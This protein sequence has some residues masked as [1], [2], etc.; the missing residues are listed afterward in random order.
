MHNSQTHT[1]TTL[2]L[3]TLAKA[4]R[5]PNGGIRGVADLI[6]GRLFALQLVA[7]FSSVIGY[8]V[9]LM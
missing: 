8:G 1:D 3:T 7:L 9:A 4:D 5:R 2:D 6:M